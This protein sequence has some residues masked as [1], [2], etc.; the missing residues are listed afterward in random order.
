M[1]QIITQLE[2]CGIVI[3]EGEN[4]DFFPTFHASQ[5]LFQQQYKMREFSEY[6]DLV[7]TLLVAEKITCSL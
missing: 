2:F 6:S 4:L 5:V 1:H 7:A 3:T